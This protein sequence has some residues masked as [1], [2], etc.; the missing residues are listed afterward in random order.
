MHFTSKESPTMFLVKSAI[1]VVEQSIIPLPPWTLEKARTE[2]VPTII[3]ATSR[4]EHEMRNIF[5]RFSI[6]PFLAFSISLRVIRF[7]M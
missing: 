4:N 1:C 3:Q 7:T 6:Y 5:W 2:S